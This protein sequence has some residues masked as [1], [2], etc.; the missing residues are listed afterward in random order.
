MIFQP[1]TQHYPHNL[2]KEK[3]LDLID[4]ADHCRGYYFRTCQNVCDALSFLFDNIY[5]RFGTKLYRQ[6][7]G[8]PMGTNCV[9]L[10][11]DLFLFCFER[12]FLKNLSND[13]QADIIKAF[14]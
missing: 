8:I 12:N 5:M 3:L 10:I 14:N 11:V 1:C 7:V 2:I 6:I 9:P 4:S 13:N